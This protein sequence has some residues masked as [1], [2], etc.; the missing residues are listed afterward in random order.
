MS[1][2]FFIEHSFPF[3]LS[4]LDTSALWCWHK[5]QNITSCSDDADTSF[6]YDL[7]VYE[8]DVHFQDSVVVP[9]SLSA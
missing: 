2:P 1:W 7:R 6:V 4:F 8:L 3:S 5:C 9:T